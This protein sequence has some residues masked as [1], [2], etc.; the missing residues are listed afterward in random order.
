MKTSNKILLALFLLPFITVLFIMLTLHAKIKNGDYITDQ[1]LEEKNNNRYTVQPFTEIY[2]QN[3]R[4]GNVTITKADSFSIKYSKEIKDNIEYRLNGNRLFVKSLGNNY[5]NRVVIYCPSFNSIE[6]DS[7]AVSVDSMSLYNCRIAVGASSS[8]SFGAQ[9]DT[10]SLN[11]KDHS[12]LSFT[13]T[14]KVNVLGLAMGN[15]ATLN[16]TEGTIKNRGEMLLADSA[17]LNIDGRT[18][19][20]FINS[21]QAVQP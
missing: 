4:Y 1:Q 17:T 20:K 6:A 14:A 11:L 12:D 7:S 21:P 13:S 5:Y 16:Q 10:L 8:L 2:L 18:M 3:F 19:Q 15:H 9:A